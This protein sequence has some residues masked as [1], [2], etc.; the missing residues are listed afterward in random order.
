MSS[1]NH[2]N[3]DK[4]DEHFN[5]LQSLTQ[6]QAKDHGTS[7]QCDM[8]KELQAREPTCIGYVCCVCDVEFDIATELENHMKTHDNLLTD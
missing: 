4:C 6:H 8:C 5:D 3:C 7:Y 2:Y 1:G